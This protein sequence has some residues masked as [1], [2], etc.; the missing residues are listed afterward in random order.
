MMV[1]LT[2]FLLIDGRRFDLGFSALI[3]GVSLRQ[4]HKNTRIFARSIEV[5]IPDVWFP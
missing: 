2:V 3:S 1:L 5:R 4:T